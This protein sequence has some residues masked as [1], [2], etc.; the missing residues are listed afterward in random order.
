VAALRAL[1]LIEE[2]AFRPNL[3]GL[4]LDL[5]VAGFD[6]ILRARQAEFL[7]SIGFEG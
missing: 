3:G 6:A 4:A 5:G 1:G 7:G 2:A